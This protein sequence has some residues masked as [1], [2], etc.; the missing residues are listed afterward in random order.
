MEALFEAARQA[1]PTCQLNEPVAS[2]EPVTAHAHVAPIAGISFRSSNVSVSC[3]E[4]T[5]LLV[6]VAEL[7]RTNGL[8][9]T[10]CVCEHPLLDES[11]WVAANHGSGC[12]FAILAEACIEQMVPDANGVIYMP[13]YVSPDAVDGALPS[14]GRMASVPDVRQ[15]G[16]VPSREGEDE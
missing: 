11:P 1:V 16:I 7:Q 6:S 12:A 9:T 13:R 14:T 8:R 5:L 15:E 10:C 2:A 4:L 3:S